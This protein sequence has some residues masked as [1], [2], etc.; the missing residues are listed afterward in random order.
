MPILELDRE[1]TEGGIAEDEIELAVRGVGLDGART[2]E[3]DV[4]EVED[5][6]LPLPG[7]TTPAPPTRSSY[8]SP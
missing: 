3:E 7:A 5:D 4:V 1:S 6:K 2:L 8:S